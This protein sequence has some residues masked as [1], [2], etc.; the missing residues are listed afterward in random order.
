M[1]KKNNKINSM[2]R[3]KLNHTKARMLTN[4]EILCQQS[5]IQVYLFGKLMNGINEC[6]EMLWV[7][8][9]IDAMAEVCNVATSAE[10]QQHFSDQF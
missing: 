8:V 9:G 10:L 4:V 2:I 6:F 5:R 3:L 1:C 7:G